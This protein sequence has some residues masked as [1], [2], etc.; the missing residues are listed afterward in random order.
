MAEENERNTI[1]SLIHSAYEKNMKMTN[2]VEA[3]VRHVLHQRRLWRDLQ[4]QYGTV[5]NAEVWAQSQVLP[6]QFIL[7]NGRSRSTTVRVR[8]PKHSSKL[9]LSHITSAMYDEQSDDDSD[10]GLHDNSFNRKFLS[11]ETSIPEDA[12]YDDD[13]MSISSSSSLSSD[14]ECDGYKVATPHGKSPSLP[15]LHNRSNTYVPLFPKQHRN[16]IKKSAQRAAYKVEKIGNGQ[17]CIT[18]LSY[19]KATIPS[20]RHSTGNVVT[21]SKSLYSTDN[22]SNVDRRDSGFLD[23][24]EEGEDVV[25]KQNHVRRSQSLGT[26]SKCP[27]KQSQS[28]FD[29]PHLRHLSGRIF[30]DGHTTVL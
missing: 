21:P 30:I 19:P 14:D 20:R 29:H 10:E 4:S 24:H 8:S 15:R 13:S 2:G 26:S 27:S 7:C 6:Q 5:P 9:R 1:C 11:Y 22:N 17:I 12:E 25:V 18:S 28:V 3:P 23:E 16:Q